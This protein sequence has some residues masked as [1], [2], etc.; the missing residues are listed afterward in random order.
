MNRYGKL[1]GI[2]LPAKQRER[3]GYRSVKWH[4][5]WKTDVSAQSFSLQADQVHPWK[6]S[7][8]MGG[9]LDSSGTAVGASP[10]VPPRCARG[11]A[12]TQ[13]KAE[14]LDL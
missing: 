11:C 7:C 1:G 2:A 6:M 10:Q 9:T 4:M 12:K 13:T 5:D 3:Q 8:T 14:L